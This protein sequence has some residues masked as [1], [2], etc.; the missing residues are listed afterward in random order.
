MA[1]LITFTVISS[2]NVVVYLSTDR[3]Q[4]GSED[5]FQHTWIQLAFRM[6]SVVVFW[7]RMSGGFLLL[8]MR[9]TDMIKKEA[10]PPLE[11]NSIN[12]R[13]MSNIIVKDL[14]VVVVKYSSVS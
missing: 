2:F 3:T 4:Y 6:L 12:D 1:S 7:S 5:G 10:S 8:C 14:S 9:C 11:K 13:A